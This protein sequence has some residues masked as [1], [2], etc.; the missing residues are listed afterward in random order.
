VSKNNLKKIDI[1]KKLSE[2]KGFSTLLAKEI[3]NDLINILSSHLKEKNLN[4]K[5]LGSFKII[6]K[7]ERMGRNPIT[8]ETHTISARKSVSFTVSKKLSKL[9]NK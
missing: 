7:K 9:I 8:K 5:N 4:F 3:I 2:K 6:K 1:A